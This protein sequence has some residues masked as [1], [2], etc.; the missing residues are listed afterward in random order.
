MKLN[1]LFKV[2]ATLLVAATVLAGCKFE[3]TTASFKEDARNGYTAAW[4]YVEKTAFIE[5]S[6]S[7]IAKAKEDTLVSVAIIAQDKLDEKAV[8]DAIDFYSLTDATDDY[9]AVGRGAALSDKKIIKIDTQY[10]TA[11]SPNRYQ[12]IYGSAGEWF[13]NEACVGSIIELSINT[14]SITK[15]AFAIVVDATKLKDKA[16]NLIL[17]Y[18]GNEKCGEES[19]SYIE[20]ISV[21]AKAN[22]DAVDSITGG[23]EEIAP[24]F[25]LTCNGP[26]YPEDDAGK[27]TGVLEFR[28]GYPSESNS[29]ET[30]YGDGFASDLGKM[31]S[32]RT[33]AIGESKW[34]ESPLTWDKDDVAH[35]YVA[36]TSALAYGTKYQIVIKENNSLEWAA[37]KDWYGHTPRIS[38]NNRNRIGYGSNWGLPDGTYTYFKDSPL[39]IVNTPD[40]SEA[41]T[42]LTFTSNEYDQGDFDNIQQNLLYVN[43]RTNAVEIG[44]D[45]S[46]DYVSVNDIRFGAYD[47]FVITDNK[48]NILKTKTPVVYKKDDKGVYSVIIELENKN[49]SLIDGNSN[50]TIKVWV[51][52]KTTINGNKAY[53]SQ[54][55][56]GAPAV[57]DDDLLTGYVQIM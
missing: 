45:D 27:R 24:T 11:T 46:N 38:Y 36:K 40:N 19:D 23:Q 42:E 7:Y 54:T 16:G 52:E 18:N 21:G 12:D 53:P 26:W 35:R 32:I 3:G 57:E 28:V 48:M 55:K 43:I 31:Y 4:D 47:G 1:K 51:G 39:Y 50:S 17:N 9:Y 8:L 22:G 41:A 25:S 30:V 5:V 44:I 56:F 6:T 15:S 2:A 10:F 20:Y 13:D 37:A 29:T 14:S 33:L 49:F 34:T